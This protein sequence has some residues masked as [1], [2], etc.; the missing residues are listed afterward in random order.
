VTQTTTAGLEYTLPF[1]TRILADISV[2]SGRGSSRKTTTLGIDY[3][4]NTDASILLGYRL[5][6]F[7]STGSA[8]EQQRSDYKSNVATAEFSIKF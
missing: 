2:E 1:N 5:I 3:T 7:A 6:D 4:L 8:A